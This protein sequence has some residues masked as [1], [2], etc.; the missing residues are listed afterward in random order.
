MA[1]IPTIQ[2]P[3]VVGERL[4][5]RANGKDTAHLETIDELG[6]HWFHCASGIAAKIK[7]PVFATVDDDGQPAALIEPPVAEPVAPSANPVRPL[8]EPG[9]IG[10]SSPRGM[11]ATGRPAGGRTLVPGR[12]EFYAAVREAVDSGEHASLVDAHQAVLAAWKGP[13]ATRSVNSVRN[14]FCDHGWRSGIM[15]K[16]EATRRRWERQH[17]AEAAARRAAELVQPPCTPPA[18]PV[19]PPCKPAA[20]GGRGPK[21]APERLAFYLA[22]K[23][24]VDRQAGDTFAEIVAAVA[25]GR[26]SAAVPR[27]PVKACRSYFDRQGWS[28]QVLSRQELATR[29]YERKQAAKAA[30]PTPPAES[31]AQGTMPVA[32]LPEV[33]EADLDMLI[34]GIETLV[35]DLR[36]GRQALRLARRIYAVM[37]E[38]VA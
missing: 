6:P 8:P 4:L 31:A 12:A 19:Q 23:R 22:V 5:I 36:T 37:C 33:R 7:G 24:E 32:D 29:R 10:S 17:A 26:S 9:E 14:Y 25:Q 38:E 15:S 13:G 2:R 16:S 34:E 3:L 30:A 18:E 35:E 21:P 20:G 1:E 27:E 11:G 28:T